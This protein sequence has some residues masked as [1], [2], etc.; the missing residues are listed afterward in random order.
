MDVTIVYF[1]RGSKPNYFQFRK[2]LNW[3]KK[4]VKNKQRINYYKEVYKESKD[5]EKFI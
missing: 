4:N 1:I 5:K 2:V 3:Y